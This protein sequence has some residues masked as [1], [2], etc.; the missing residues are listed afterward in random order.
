MFHC[1][2]LCDAISI[3]AIRR[4]RIGRLTKW[5]GSGR[6]QS[7]P[8]PDTILVFAWRNCGKQKK[9]VSQCPGQDSNQAPLHQIKVSSSIDIS[10]NLFQLVTFWMSSIVVFLFRTMFRRLDCLHSY[11]QSPLCWAQLSTFYTSERR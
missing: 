7:G 6:K 11:V 10:R 4:R 2:L 8:N 9:K 5:E 3:E 1:G